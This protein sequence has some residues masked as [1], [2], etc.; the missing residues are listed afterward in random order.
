MPAIIVGDA[1]R[2]SFWS[3][4]GLILALGES[5]KKESKK[6]NKK[7]RSKNYNDV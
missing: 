1:F 7:L 4:F 6:R 3:Y 5:G 2:C